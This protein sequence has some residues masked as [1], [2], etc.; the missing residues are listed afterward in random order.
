VTKSYK[1][2][3]ADLKSQKTNVYEY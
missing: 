1:V 2:E 3:A